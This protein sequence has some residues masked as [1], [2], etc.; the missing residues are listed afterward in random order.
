AAVKKHRKWRPDETKEAQ[1][2]QTKIKGKDKKV[3]HKRQVSKRKGMLHDKEWKEN[4]RDKNVRKEK[5][6]RSESGEE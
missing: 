2:K 4:E 3:E 1:E 5:G 6:N